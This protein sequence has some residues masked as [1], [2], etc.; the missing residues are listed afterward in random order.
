MYLS[1]AIVA[2]ATVVLVVV[3]VRLFWGGL[4][5]T[6]YFTTDARGHLSIPCVRVYVFVCVCVCVYACL[7][8]S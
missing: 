6:T 2:A 5:P 3:V 1:C 4:Y 7:Y 8:I